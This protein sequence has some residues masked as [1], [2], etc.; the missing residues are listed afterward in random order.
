MHLPRQRV[1]VDVA[2]ADKSCDC[3]ALKMRIGD[4]VYPP[5]SFTVLVTAH[6]KYACPRC[7]D[8][9]VE[10]PPLAVASGLFNNT[11]QRIENLSQRTA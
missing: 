7:H 8:G 11:A 9:V 3:G 10:A 5:A 1:E 6:A 4:A 2:D